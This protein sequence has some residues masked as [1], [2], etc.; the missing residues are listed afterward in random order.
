[1]YVIFWPCFAMVPP[2]WAR[3]LRF[4]W[5]CASF[6]NLHRHLCPLIQQVLVAFANRH[7]FLFDELDHLLWCPAY[8]VASLQESVEIDL[9]KHRVVPQALQQIILPFAGL[10]FVS[11]RSAVHPDALMSRLPIRAARHGGHQ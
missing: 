7:N 1:M 5:C 8:E 9:P 2:L 3:S 11:N 4:S 10:K 6:R